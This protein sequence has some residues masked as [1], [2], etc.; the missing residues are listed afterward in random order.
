MLS[1]VYIGDGVDLLVSDDKVVVN[2]YAEDSSHHEI[3]EH[4]VYNVATHLGAEVQH[5][6]LTE[7]HQ[8]AVTNILEGEEWKEDDSWREGTA[9]AYIHAWATTKE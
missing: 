3:F 2:C 8:K 6:E 7:E 5:L 4:T 9:V 1:M